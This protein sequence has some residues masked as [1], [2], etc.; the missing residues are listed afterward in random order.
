MP[1]LEIFSLAYL[2]SEE[3]VLMFIGLDPSTADELRDDNTVTRC[4]CYAQRWGYGALY[5]LNLFGYR[6]TDPKDMLT[7]ADP[8][9]PENDNH[10][11]ETAARAG[12]VVAAWGNN[13]IYRDRNLDVKRLIPGPIHCLGLTNR[14]QPV[15][16]LYQKGDIDPLPWK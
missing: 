4:R 5:M 12:I 3:T 6:A 2:G 11:V 16:P 8:V 15:H 13:G 10:I 14:N 9:G 7:V 1:L